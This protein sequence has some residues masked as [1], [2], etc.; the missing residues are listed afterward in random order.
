MNGADAVDNADAPITD[1]ASG[2]WQRFFRFVEK[3]ASGCWVWSGKKNRGYGR[4]SFRGRTLKAHRFSYRALVGPIPSGFH[5]DHLCRRRACVNPAHIEAV[6][7][8]ENTLR[9]DG[10]T[11]MNA[12]KTHC[13]SGHELSGP[14]LTGRSRANFRE[15]RVC[16]ALRM[17]IARK[18]AHGGRREC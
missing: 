16:A 9:G 8:A 11:A 12:R 17:R 2:E 10:F 15:C 3:D 18:R 4:F 5:A 7:P 6:S 1:V 14:N 13:P